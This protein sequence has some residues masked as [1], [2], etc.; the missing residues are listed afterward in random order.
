MAG[1]HET[2]DRNQINISFA[3]GNIVTP[4][5]ERLEH[6]L[7]IFKE[8]SMSEEEKFRFE[9]H[10]EAHKIEWKTIELR[11]RTTVRFNKSSIWLS[12][13][14]K[15]IQMRTSGAH[16][17][18][19]EQRRKKLDWITTANIAQGWASSRTNEPPKKGFE[20]DCLRRD[21]DCSVASCDC[22]SHPT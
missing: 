17:R 14:H 10:C 16:K 20:N 13:H 21:S 11:M 2:S 8:F 18:W 12:V 3:G 1:K 6:L 5:D 9:F 15:L 19:L 7:A 22:F 4:H